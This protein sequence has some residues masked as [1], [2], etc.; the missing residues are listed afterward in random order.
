MHARFLFSRNVL[1]QS[2]H[3]PRNR[4]A[5]AGPSRGPEILLAGGAR[6][7]E[8]WNGNA[9]IR[10]DIQWLY[11]YTVRAVAPDVKTGNAKN[12]AWCTPWRAAVA[13]K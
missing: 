2:K 8:Y 7:K 9:Q 6:V 5:H 12:V 1:A 3:G 11:I 4:G 10:V 13:R